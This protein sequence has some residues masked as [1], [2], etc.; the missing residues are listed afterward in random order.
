[1]ADYVKFR[2]TAA[3]VGVSMALMALVAGVAEKIQAA[4]AQIRATPAAS[5][6]L[7][8][9]GS[10]TGNTKSA[11]IKLEQ[12][13]VKMHSALIG[14]E[15]TLAHKYMKIR[16]ANAQFLKI[17]DANGKW[18]KI[19]DANAQFL[20]INDAN[21]EFL[22]HDGTA[23]N[24]QLLGNMPPNA[25]FQGHGNVVSGAQTVGSGG[26]QQLVATPDGAISILIGLSQPAA[27]GPVSPTLT[28]R[29]N[30]G[31]L[32]PAVQD[33]G[34]NNGQS[35]PSSTGGI[36]LKPGDN[37]IPLPAGT[38]QFHL[39]T[40]PSQSG[41]F[42]SGGFNSIIAVLVSLEPNPSDG[43]QYLASGQMLDGGA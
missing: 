13:Y 2:L 34:T 22:K 18:L 38:S 28:V 32:L 33:L 29:N 20:K 39:Q 35:A 7:L 43:S 1:M 31:Q 12:K 4:P 30:T 42:Q 9:L 5:T 16:D 36:S 19:D 27:G 40:F 15:N 41:G 6:K 10:V 8:K 17:T 24:S 37:T 11:F 25:F 14:L 26:T 23:A 3:K 21:Q